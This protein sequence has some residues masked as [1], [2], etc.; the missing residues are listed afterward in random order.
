MS[1]SLVPPAVE[2]AG[3][4][5]RYGS[6]VAVDGASFTAAPG[7]V[8][9]VLGLNGAGK[10]STIECCEGLRRP[11]GGSVRVLGRD[12]MT[13]GAW[14]RPRVGVM[15]QDGGLPQAARAGDLLDLAAAMY[16]DPLD[17]PGLVS[18]LDLGG[19]LR[20]PVRRL[21]GGE[22]QRLALAVALVGRPDVAF[23]DEPTAGLD[24]QARL[25]VWD[26]IGG[27]RAGGVAVVLTTHLLDEAERLADHVVLMA[28][29]RVV[30]AGTPRE[31][32]GGS[33]H[34]LTFEAPPGLDLGRLAPLLSAGIA[35]TEV[36]PGH[37]VVANRTPEAH[38]LP[39]DVA[40]TTAWCA[41]LGIMPEG[42]V[43]GRRSLEDVFLEIAARQAGATEVIGA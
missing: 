5:K 20:T 23:L 31:L 6:R 25:A 17:L 16:A 39:A 32:T 28:A 4:V 33:D 18:T 30:A 36:R 12:P 8:T 2:V 24:P 35:A 10:T 37:Y 26:L 13:D 42:L 15:L 3:L 21:S 9:A 29:G 27:L 38:L 1:R 43:L 41:Q 34:T 11:D 19:R 22:R 7:A 40:A 14:L